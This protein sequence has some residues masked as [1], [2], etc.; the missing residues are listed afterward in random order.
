MRVAE[1]VLEVLVAH[2]VRQVFGIP[3]DA[4]ND[5]TF[6][7]SERED[8]DFILV[9]HEEA[10][11]FMASAQAKLTGELTACVGTAGPGAVHL[12]NGL[13][14]AKLDHAPVIAITGQT[15]TEY[16]GT[17]YHQEIDTER[18]FSDVAE[19]SRTIMT[20]DQAM[21]LMLEAAKAAISAPGVAH[22]SVPTDI[23]GK[24][25]KVERRDF[26]LGSER[27]EMRPCE[28]SLAEAVRLMD[29]AKKP[30]ILAGIGAASAR[31]ELLALSDKLR[32]PIVRTLRA[33]D[34]IDECD[35]ACI[36]G[37]G[38][39]G[40]SVGSRAMENCD[41]LVIVGADFP[42]T[43]FYPEDVPI[44][45]IEPNPG[46]M[47]RRAAVAGPL[48][49][50]A[51][52]TLTEILPRLVGN[53]SDNFYGEMQARKKSEREGFIGAEQSNAAPIKPQRAIAELAASA[54]EDAIFVCDT[55][56]ATAWT[57]RHLPVKTGQR[58]TLS[59]ALASMAF[60]LPG[61]IGAALSYQGRQVVAIAGDGGFAMLMADFVTAVRY[62]LPIV[63]VI[64]NNQ[65]LGFIALEQLAKGL[66]EHSIDLANPNFKAFAEACGGVGYVVSEAEQ[67]IPTYADAFAAGRPAVVD[68][69]VDP[70][71]LIMPP[72][73]T[74]EQAW[75]FGIAKIRET[76]S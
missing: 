11:A 14:D 66:P 8:M 4:I 24:R 69:R 52:A 9:R 76:L 58:F 28:A 30:V 55:G 51:K 47:G 38:L 60:A 61:A 64:L 49:G 39:L 36:G 46:R 57:A 40:S 10:G 23:A 25:V 63:C 18:L 42:Y 17:G 22:I 15:A 68:V 13:Y 3:G 2:G 31:E 34:F 16:I 59:S 50:H 56:T 21:P 27:G 32:A 20:P 1:V 62:E 73:I 7:I 54:A 44:V 70:D 74:V 5:I 72:K 33:K 6:A 12:L 45:Q 35:D 67:L 41:L 71:E 65:K 19:Y 29:A 48:R 37:L 43:S 53:L 75:N 26:S